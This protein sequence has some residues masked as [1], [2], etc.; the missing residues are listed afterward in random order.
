MWNGIMTCFCKPQ[1]Y[2]LLQALYQVTILLVLNFWGESILNLKQ[3][4]TE[5][6]NM[7]KNSL[8]F[9]GFV[10]CQVGL[11]AKFFIIDEIILVG[12]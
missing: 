4:G 10:L 2:L 8:I 7:V 6:A 9:N 11:P 12:E 1:L 5:H 3:D